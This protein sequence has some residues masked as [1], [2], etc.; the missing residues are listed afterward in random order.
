[1]NLEEDSKLNLKPSMLA[2]L[3]HWLKKIKNKKKIK[4]GSGK[5]LLE[6][7]QT[8]TSCFLHY[9][10]VVFKPLDLKVMVHIRWINS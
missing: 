9:N 4:T 3:F 8:S 10:K 6:V 2:T 7:S 1:M 5:H